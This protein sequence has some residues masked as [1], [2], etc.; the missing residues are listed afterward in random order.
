MMKLILASGSPSR[1]ALLRRAG[2]DPVVQVS[3]VDEE[4]ISADTPVDLVE[5]LARAKAGA[6]AEGVDECLVL[7]CDS[8]LEFDGTVHGKPGTAEVAL[9]RWG[10]ISG[11]SGVFHT[12]HCVI[13]A[14]SGRSRSAVSSTFVR[15]GRPTEDEIAGYVATGE[16]I[17]VAG[18]FK[19]DGLGC[20][21]VE[22]IDGDLGTLQGLSLPTLRRLLADLDVALPELW[23]QG[24]A[25]DR[26]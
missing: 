12:G 3:G 10:Q 8:V 14:T 23:A 19:I 5:R 2:L 4:A 22:S 7:G 11:R 17:A 26:P 9:E 25:R 6:V 18:A 21:F 16:P 24:S 20:W 13:D 1:L 15:F